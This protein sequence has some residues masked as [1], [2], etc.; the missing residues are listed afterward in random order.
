MESER[1][2]AKQFFEWLAEEIPGT[3]PGPLDYLVNNDEFRVSGQS[4][5]QVNRFLVSSMDEWAIGPARGARVGG[6]P[7]ST[8]GV[9]APPES[10]EFPETIRALGRL[11]PDRRTSPSRLSR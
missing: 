9:S 7:D 5:F 10:P 6:R 3:V 8:L 2:V 4:F 11:S 1:P